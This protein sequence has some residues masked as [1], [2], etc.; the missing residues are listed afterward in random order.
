MKN[1]TKKLDEILDKKQLGKILDYVKRNNGDGR[2]DKMLQHLD[3]LAQ[4]KLSDLAT[5]VRRNP[6]DAHEKVK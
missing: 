4:P 1:L 5:F 6:S 2:Y 3:G